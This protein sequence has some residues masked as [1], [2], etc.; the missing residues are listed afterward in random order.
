MLSRIKRR[1]VK[2]QVKGA[3]RKFVTGP[4]NFGKKIF[5]P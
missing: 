1:G 2:K 5:D 3:A 4:I